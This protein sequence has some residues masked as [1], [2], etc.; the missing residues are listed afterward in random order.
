LNQTS[1]KKETP[2]VPY[3]FRDETDDGSYKTV[4]ESIIP[5]HGTTKLV[6][7]RKQ[8]LK[9]RLDEAKTALKK[10]LV[11]TVELV[12]DKN[13]GPKGSLSHL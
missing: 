7:S 6:K 9:L 2:I 8:G 5:V 13:K 12:F 11:K 4:S 1:E 3:L 10:P